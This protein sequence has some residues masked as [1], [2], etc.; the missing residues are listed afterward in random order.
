[1]DSRGAVSVAQTAGEQKLAAAHAQLMHAQGLQLKFTTIPEPK[2]PD[3]LLALGRFMATLA[4]A[5][6]YIF[7]GGV[8]L[9]VA[10]ILFLI[11]REI[12]RARFARFRRKPK[13][14]VADESWRPDAVE[15]RALLDDAD[16]LAGE[17]RYGEAVHL[18]LFRSIE[19][20]AGRKPGVVRPALTSRDIGDM[21]VMP[22]SARSAFAHIASVVER[23]FF[24][25]REIGRE[26]FVDC[27][28]AYERFAF[29][30]G[31]S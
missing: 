8:I 30:E 24:G 5:F 25:G 31:W 16:R 2:T 4:P 10:G 7:W 22:P 26:D 18:I 15:A 11:G 1:V 20:L 23:T 9:M 14:A 29:A 21:A 3:W 6:K 28:G 19:D 12:W 27:R 17:G 13:S